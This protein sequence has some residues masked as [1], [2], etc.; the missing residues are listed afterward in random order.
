MCIQH[1]PYVGTYIGVVWL[2]VD[3]RGD[4]NKTSCVGKR[5]KYELRMYQLN[6]NNSWEGPV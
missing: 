4:I 6:R 2:E 5:S 1:P 3:V